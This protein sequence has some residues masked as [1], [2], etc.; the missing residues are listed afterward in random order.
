MERGKLPDGNGGKTHQLGIGTIFSA[1][2][3][4]TLFVSNSQSS[5]SFS[6]PFPTDL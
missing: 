5:T 6:L 3:K 4:S 2:K 1:Y